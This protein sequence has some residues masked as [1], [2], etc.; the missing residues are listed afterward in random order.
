MKKRLL[1]L[2]LCLTLSSAL[3]ACG[4]SQPDDPETTE[5]GPEPPTPEAIQADHFSVYLD[6]SNLSD[7]ILANAVQDIDQ[8]SEDQGVT[9]SV[10]QTLG[11]GRT[12]YVAFE[13]TYPEGT[14][15]SDPNIIL[16]TDPTTYG[17]LDVTLAQGAVTDPENIT[18]APLYTRNLQTAQTDSNVISGILTVQ[19]AE[20]SLTG[21]EISLV[22]HD[23]TVYET[24]HTISWT[25]E[26]TGPCRETDLLD[27][28]GNTVG[29]ATLTPFSLLFHMQEDALS[30][31]DQITLLDA[32]GMQLDTCAYGG[33]GGYIEGLFFVPIQPDSAATVNIGPYTGQFQ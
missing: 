21:Q 13:M 1:S 6:L 14:E 28:A 4:S 32:T 2:F 29:T 7:D 10:S 33:D 15:L 11:D 24:V 26:N 8:S 3:C 22:V 12:L 27:E 23:L 5:P 25:V 19:T 9:L 20:G 31:I 16:S 30:L 18:P 17:A